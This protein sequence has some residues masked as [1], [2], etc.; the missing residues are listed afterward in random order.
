MLWHHMVVD[1]QLERS[2]YE[3]FGKEARPILTKAI[4][5]F[6]DLAFEIA[7]STLVGESKANPALEKK[8]PI[9]SI[10]RAGPPDWYNQHDR[11]S[12]DHHA[13][14]L[15]MKSKTVKWKILWL[16]VDKEPLL[17][18]PGEMLW[19]GQNY[20][21]KFKPS[22]DWHVYYDHIYPW[23]E[24]DLVGQCYRKSDLTLK[25]T[26]IYF[27]PAWTQVDDN[28]YVT[29]WSHVPSEVMEILPIE[30]CTQMDL[31]KTLGNQWIN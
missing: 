5:A 3:S 18:T 31:E 26:K 4:K 21:E 15:H 9:I 25:H 22:E 2:I 7:S 17:D 27:H 10:Y 29:D 23:N 30:T 12:V 20:D 28:N 19:V 14:K 8:E 6:P 11:S 16:G 13:I 1:G 24:K